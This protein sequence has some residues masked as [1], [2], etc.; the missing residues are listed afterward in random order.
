MHTAGTGNNVLRQDLPQPYKAE[1]SDYKI[2]LLGL[3]REE[4]KKVFIKG[5]KV[6]ITPD[7]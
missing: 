3:G 6:S 7:E 5:Y 4:N 1:K 2:F